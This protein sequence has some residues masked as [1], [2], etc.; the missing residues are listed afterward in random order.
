MAVN[1]GFGHVYT[2]RVQDSVNS[3]KGVFDP[4]RIAWEE[5]ENGKVFID[6]V[7]CRVIGNG[8]TELVPPGPAPL[9]PKTMRFD[10]HY[11]HF[12]PTTGLPSIT[13]FI[14][15]HV[16]ADIYD[17]H[18]DNEVWAYDYRSPSQAKGLF[19]IYQSGKDYPMSSHQFD[20]V[21]SNLAGVTVLNRFFQS[22]RQV[23]NCVLKN[24][25]DVIDATSLFYSSRRCSLVSIN[26]LDFSSVLYMSNMFRLCDYLTS[27]LDITLSGSVLSCS[28]AFDGAKHVPSGALALYNSLSSQSTLPAN[29]TNCFTNCGASTTTG[30]AELAQIPTSWGGTMV[31]DSAPPISG[32]DFD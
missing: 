4:G 12:D 3:G 7:R 8:H 31:E 29:Y 15:T 30:A 27:P 1:T 17:F 2:S 23:K 11:D 5:D 14:W 9:A 6:G 26:S 16:E 10:F 28:G 32:N 25:G 24:T 22:G 21:D 13:G 19:D 18:Y 20:I